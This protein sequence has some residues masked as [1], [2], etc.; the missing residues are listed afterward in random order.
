MLW[1]PLKKE[2]PYR[3][4]QK[5]MEKSLNRISKEINKNGGLAKYNPYK[6]E[7]LT[8]LVKPEYLVVRFQTEIRLVCVLMV[9]IIGQNLD[10]TK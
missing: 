1:E 10:I 9:H 8:E 3:E 6:Y 5:V 4:I 7:L 2:E